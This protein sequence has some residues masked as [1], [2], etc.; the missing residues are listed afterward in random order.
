MQIRRLLLIDDD[1]DF[2][3]LLQDRLGPSGFE[4]VLPPDPGNPLGH[5]KEVRPALILIAVELPDKVGYALC[6]K[7]KKGL[8]RDI[9]VILTTRSVPASGFRSHRKLKVHA[10]E[11]IDKRGMTEEEV[12]A[13][14]DQLV[15]LVGY[16]GQTGSTWAASDE[17]DAFD[18]EELVDMSDLVEE[19]SLAS[20]EVG[21][22]DDELEDGGHSAVPRQIT[23]EGSED[24][25]DPRELGADADDD[26]S[27]EFPHPGHVGHEVAPLPGYRTAARG[28]HAEEE[29]ED[30]I[31]S[32]NG[33]GESRRHGSDA[34]LEDRGGHD[35]HGDHDPHGG[36][37]EHRGHAHREVEAVPIGYGPDLRSSDMG[38]FESDR[39]AV[40]QPFAQLVDPV[41]APIFAAAQPEPAAPPAPLETPEP[42]APVADLDLGLDQLASQAQ[43]E[44]SDAYERHHHS[45]TADLEKQIEELR[46]DL[47]EARRAP[48]AAAAS[49]FSRE[50]EFLNLREVINKKEKLIL[51][52]NDQ[53]DDKER[54]LLSERERRRESDRVRSDLDTKNLELEQ[55]LLGANEELAHLR[56]ERATLAEQLRRQSDSLA[57][58]RA[59]AEQ[60]SRL[61]ERERAT[62]R[63]ERDS[64]ARKHLAALDQL[65]H[66]MET[67]RAAAEEAL[68]DRHSG[69]LRS[70]KEAY[71]ETTAEKDRGFGSALALAEVRRQEELTAAQRGAEERLQ[72]ELAEK[73]RLHQEEVDALRREQ[74][75]E[76]ESLVRQGQDARQALEDRH[77][78]QLAR[79]EEEQSQA[80]AAAEKRRA[81]EVSDA[82][83]RRVMEL[84]ELEERRRRELAAAAEERTRSE[85]EL[86]EKHDSARSAMEREHTEEREGLERRLLAREDE[87]RAREEE[88][89]RTRETLRARE[90]TVASLEATLGDREARIT[91]QR[92]EL[93]ELERQNTGYQ[94]QVLR[95]FQKIRADE[96]IVARAK[97]A[98]AIALTL[99][100]EPEQPDAEAD[101]RGDE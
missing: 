64:L 91:G 11:Y 9:P 17:A 29:S 55:S 59:D 3:H 62:W 14:V 63:E 39:T 83:K 18:V 45:R 35:P 41:S 96:A 101:A 48:T 79:L 73:R 52:L 2:Q 89:S 74:A 46:A 54:Q 42:S 44:Q 78:G 99:L 16:D 80:L 25:F 12:V 24:G 95:A 76:L 36:Q 7:A 27:F 100:D 94:E 58:V 85:T 60:L 65:K 49:S 20:T 93:D 30:V 72:L 40:A 70:L 33:A 53:I 47:E 88:L 92:Q 26:G 82:D 43:E 32:G 6:N 56:G 67:E 5:V 23:H 97:K 87:L 13:K 22:A 68:R 90:Q 66:D 50:R 69:D 38:E 34:G 4:I 37:G 75:T 51:D 86:R 71:E 81:T 98:M 21:P 10:D 19:S 28:T 61:L 1:P 15:G 57:A 8:A 31:A 84:A 77:S